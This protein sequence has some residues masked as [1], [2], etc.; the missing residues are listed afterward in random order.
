MPKKYSLKKQ[1]HREVALAVAEV[2]VRSLPDTVIVG[3]LRRGCEV[4]GN[5]DLL[6]TSPVVVTLGGG[7]YPAPAGGT[8]GRPGRPPEGSNLG[9]RTPR[10]G[11]DSCPRA[12]GRPGPASRRGPL[13]AV[14]RCS[15]GATALT[16]YPVW[17]SS[18]HTSML[19]L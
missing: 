7:P 5:V 11:G 1:I 12:R 13:Q 14:K 10:Q 8:P 2:L 16:W 19:S 15:Q 18:G 17:H 9:L 4:V 3:S 6:T